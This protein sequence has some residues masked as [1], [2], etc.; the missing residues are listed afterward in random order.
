MQCITGDKLP[1]PIIAVAGGGM[2]L[3]ILCIAACCCCTGKSSINKVGDIE[4]GTN[5]KV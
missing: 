1:L 2:L 5:K 4:D 3:V